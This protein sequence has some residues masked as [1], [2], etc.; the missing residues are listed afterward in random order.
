MSCWLSPAFPAMRAVA[1]LPAR[2]LLMTEFDELLGFLN[3]MAAIR[4]ISFLP[5]APHIRRARP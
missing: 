2:D 5:L 1:S 4:A 3:K